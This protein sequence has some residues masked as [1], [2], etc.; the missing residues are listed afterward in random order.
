MGDHMR[1]QAANAEYVGRRVFPI[2]PQEGWSEALSKRAAALAEMALAEAGYPV[3]TAWVRD[4][5]LHFVEPGV[6]DAILDRARVLVFEH[7]GIEYEVR[8][9]ADA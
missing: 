5:R 7:L 9:P 8:E 4:L 6:P 3:K 2:Q 1:E